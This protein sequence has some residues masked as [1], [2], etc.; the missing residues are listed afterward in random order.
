MAGSGGASGPRWGSGQEWGRWTTLARQAVQAQSALGR[1]SFDLARASVRGELDPLAA[2]RAYA[3]A[4]RR[5]SSRYWDT[6]SRLGAEYVHDLAAVGEE[7]VHAVLDDVSSARRPG[8]AR[9]S[10]RSRG[11]AA[12]GGRDDLPSHPAASP[13]AARPAPPVIPGS[14]S[15]DP[16][17]TSSAATSDAP[18]LVLRGALGERA[19][20]SLTV[21][22]RHPRPRRIEVG[23]DPVADEQGV[24]VAGAAL[25][26][27]PRRVTVPA[28]EEAVVRLAVELAA[29]RFEAG[30]GYRTSVRVSG[31]DDATV[32]CRILV[33]EEVQLEKAGEPG[34]H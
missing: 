10:H 34:A 27:D 23:A 4:V 12:G 29:E 21:A 26:I 5:E 14:T 30:R 24:P 16:G 33:D 6:A 9:S 3:R 8:R 32:A 22:N 20:G 25:E 11:P 13:P 19:T 28:G 31:G 17:A 18:S 1:A 15:A 2:T 7:A